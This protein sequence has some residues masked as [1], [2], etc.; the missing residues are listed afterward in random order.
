M[1]TVESTQVHGTVE[2]D[3][4]ELLTVRDTEKNAMLYA[5]GRRNRPLSEGE[6]HATIMLT[7]DNGHIDIDLDAESMDALIDAL[8]TIRNDYADE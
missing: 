4:S 6:P 2:Y 5:Q 8:V 7:T 3:A 1:R